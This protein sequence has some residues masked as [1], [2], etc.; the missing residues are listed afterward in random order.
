MRDLRGVDVVTM[1][2]AAPKSGPLVSS[3]Q[4]V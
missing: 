3:S 4:A 2:R 1:K